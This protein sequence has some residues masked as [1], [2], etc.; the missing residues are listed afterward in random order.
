MP[1][2]ITDTK[3]PGVTYHVISSEC[4]DPLKCEL[5]GGRLERESHSISCFDT[6]YPWRPI[7]QDTDRTC[8]SGSS[9]ERVIL[10]SLPL[11]AGHVGSNLISCGMF[12]C[13]SCSKIQAVMLESRVKPQGSPST[14]HLNNK[15]LLLARWP[16]VPKFAG[17]NPAEAV[18]FFGRKNPQHAFLRRGSK[19]VCSMSPICGM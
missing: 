4:S 11:P 17:W 1:V 19:D 9:K 16:L 6:A 18:G 13:N 5:N 3:R 14:N 8:C 7:W 12:S 2:A 10:T 15:R